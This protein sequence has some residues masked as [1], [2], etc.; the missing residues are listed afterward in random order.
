MRNL[1]SQAKTKT[2]GLI[3]NDNKS[4]VMPIKLDSGN[5]VFSNTCAFDSVVQLLA[6]AYCNSY[7]YASYVNKKKV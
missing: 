4:N 7:Q 2:I 3:K 6:V 5:Y 1:N